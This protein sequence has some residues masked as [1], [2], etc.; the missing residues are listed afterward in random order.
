MA[1]ATARQ[2]RYSKMA[3]LLFMA[4]RARSHR[5]IAQNTPVA[6]PWL[7]GPSPRYRVAIAV[8]GD[9]C[10]TPLE[11]ETSAA[12]ATEVKAIPDAKS[13]NDGSRM[14]DPRWARFRL[15]RYQLHPCSWSPR[16]KAPLS[17]H[18]PEN[19][20]RSRERADGRLMVPRRGLVA[21]PQP[22]IGWGRPRSRRRTSSRPARAPIVPAEHGPPTQNAERLCW[23]RPTPL[24]T[25]P[26]SPL[27]LLL[28]P[29]FL[30]RHLAGA[31]R[32]DR[33]VRPVNVRSESGVLC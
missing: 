30:G 2:A 18:S 5:P 4:S 20:H 3:R 15:S 33:V 19:S 7:H 23:G 8:G 31:E 16:P 28:T 24:S 11:G 14:A 9:G 25:R 29:F 22:G 10:A 26:N 21:A 13:Q 12:R 32:P 27:P 6:S 17:D 1:P